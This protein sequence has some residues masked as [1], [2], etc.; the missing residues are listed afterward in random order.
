MEPDL[1]NLL[2][3]G[4][5]NVAFGMFL[6]WQYKEQQKRADEREAKNDVREKELR[7]RY[8]KVIEGYMAKE[9]K[10]RETF[11]KEITEIDKRLVFLEQKTDQILE[12]T[13]DIKSKFV[14]VG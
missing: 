5:P 14:R 4:G 10:L 6:Y 3:S 9:D 8:D 11:G 1:L 13:Q 12:A 2:V 7:A